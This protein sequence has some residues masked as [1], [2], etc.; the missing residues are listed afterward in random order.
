MRNFP[1]LIYIFENKKMYAFFY[2]PIF[3][4]YIHTKYAKNSSESVFLRET[5]YLFIK[6]FIFIICYIFENKNTLYNWTLT[7]IL[8]CY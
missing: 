4:I 6:I 7:Q 2:V 1:I 8:F 5:N 3:F